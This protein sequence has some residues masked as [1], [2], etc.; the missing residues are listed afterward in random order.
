M[1]QKSYN[2]RGAPAVPHMYPVQVR[3]G[4]NFKPNARH[5]LGRV[6]IALNLGARSAAV[7]SDVDPVQVRSDLCSDHIWVSFPR[8]GL[9][10][11]ESCQ[12]KGVKILINSLVASRLVR[13][14]NVTRR[15]GSIGITQNQARTLW[16]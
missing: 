6:P 7:Q 5:E 10:V 2:I 15:T 13:C 11:N 3:F 16:E 9:R 12:A 14:Q 8:L 4:Q 1:W